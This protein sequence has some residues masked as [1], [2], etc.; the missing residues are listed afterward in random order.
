MSKKKTLQVFLEIITGRTRSGK[1]FYSEKRANDYVKSGGIVF[2]YN[3]GK[4]WKEYTEIEI[5]SIAETLNFV[6]KTEGTTSARYYRNNP[7]IKFFKVHLTD[8][9]RRTM[10]KDIIRMCDNSI[11][12]FKNFTT[13]FNLAGMPKKIKVLGGRLSRG[14]EIKF[15]STIKK[16][17]SRMLCIFDDTK[18]LF[19]NGMTD[20]ATSLFNSLNHTG[21]HLQGAYKNAGCDSIVIYHEADDI[22]A[23]FFTFA[24][25]FTQ[26][27]ELFEPTFHKI[28]HPEVLKLAKQNA[29]YLSNAPAFTHFTIQLRDLDV[30][31]PPIIKN[32]IYKPN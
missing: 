30:S 12:D 27:I 14:D 15:F 19:Q 20:S 25:H 24:T 26:F 23:D 1:T 13:L 8:D 17:F 11:F 4:D 21:T 2:V 7:E 5:L 6:D 31:K 16:Y 3:A 10:P 22:N 32:Y 9:N 28:K 18:G 29:K